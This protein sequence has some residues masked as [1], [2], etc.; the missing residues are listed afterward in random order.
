MTLR[1]RL[2]AHRK[3]PTCASCHAGLDGYGLALE[4]YDAI[5]AWRTRQDGEGL[6]GHLR[7]EIDPS[8]KLKSGRAFLN[9]KEFK[10]AM[11]MDRDSLGRA[12]AHTML[13]YALTRPVGVIDR[14][15]LDEIDQQLKAGD[16]R[17]QSVIHGITQSR[18]F[19]TK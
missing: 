3:E 18:L 8:G 9:L 19:L 6:P 4:N 5:G 13:T 7:R 14:E 2:E 1:Q 15:T 17:I 16:F 11:L 10:Q 12:F